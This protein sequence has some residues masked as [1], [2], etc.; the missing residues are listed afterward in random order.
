MKNKLLFGAILSLS[1]FGG[2]IVSVKAQVSSEDCS[3]MT[4][5]SG[6]SA[7]G[8]VS[9]TSESYTPFK[10]DPEMQEPEP[11]GGYPQKGY[12]AKN[13]RVNNNV[14]C[15]EEADSVLKDCKTIGDAICIGVGKGVEKLV[16]GRSPIGGS[17]A[18]G[19]TTSLC[20]SKATSYCE[21]EKLAALQEC[22]NQ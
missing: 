10:I 6:A 20:Q 4:L 11:I 1:I 8:S 18:G 3:P 21:G 16:S 12:K 7:C 19:I 9:N 2:H 5:D 14:S 17:V 13:S 22:A 15:N